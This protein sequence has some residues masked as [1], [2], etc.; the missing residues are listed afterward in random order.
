MH[1]SNPERLQLA[2]LLT[3]PKRYHPA[4]PTL[5]KASSRP[6]AASGHTD[7]LKKGLTASGN[8]A[9]FH[10]IPVLAS[11]AIHSRKRRQGTNCG[12]KG[13]NK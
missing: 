1:V 2:G 11:P 3:Y 13:T 6:F 12:C 10:C 4:F 7:V 8:V 9:E 5:R